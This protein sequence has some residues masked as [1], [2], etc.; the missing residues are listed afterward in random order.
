MRRRLTKVAVL[1]LL[2]VLLAT[3]PGLVGCAEEKAAEKEIVY[4]YLWDFTGRAALAVTDMYNSMMDY[5]R[6]VEE[7]NPIP[8]VKIKVITYDTKSEGA[9]IPPGYV[10]LKGKEMTILSAAPHD[11]ELLRSRFEEDKIPVFESSN[12]L[13]TL[14]SEWLVSLYGAPESQIEI[15]MHWIMDTWEGTEKP[16]ISFIG[17]GGIPFYEAQRDMTEAIC[18]QYPGKFEWLGDEMPPAGT[19]TWA[20][21]VGR[22]MGSD[23][24]MMGMSGPP[25]ASFIKE[26]RARGYE[27]KFTGPLESFFAFWELV[28]GAVPLE[29]LDGTISGTFFPWWNDDIPFILERKEYIDKYRPGEAERLMLATGGFSGWAIG[30][31]LVDAVRRAVEEVGAE[32]VDRLVMRDALRETDMV[33][34]GW[35]NPWKLIENINCLDRSVKL[36]EYRAAEDDWFAITEWEIPPSLGG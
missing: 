7:E 18:E 14:D 23:F 32:N 8:G 1:V 2:G 36:V 25:L 33:V 35:G 13:S 30:M 22:L 26:A 29:D 31:I 11:C 15:L 34:E 27:N 28:K 21:E 6:M 3:L 5:L 16:K 24:I 17:L 12:L 10:W 20:P 9:R 4:G 19:M